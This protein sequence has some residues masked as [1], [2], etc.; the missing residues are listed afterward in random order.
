[1]SQKLSEHEDTIYD[2]NNFPTRDVI[3]DLNH[4]EKVFLWDTEVGYRG[5]PSLHTLDESCHP[6]P[7]PFP[8]VLSSLT[9]LHPHLMT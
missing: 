5:I 2:V 7:L 9:T 8:Q 3:S 1:M 6:E 4:Q